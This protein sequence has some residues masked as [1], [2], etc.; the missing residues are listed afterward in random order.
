MRVREL[1][2]LFIIAG[3]AVLFTFLLVPDTEAQWS[4]AYRIRP[5]AALPATCNP[6]NGDIAYLTAGAGSPGLYV[7]TA[8]NTWTAAGTSGATGDSIIGAAASFGWTGRSRIHSAADGRVNFTNAAGADFNR[9]T[10]GPEAVS[11]I[12][13]AQA[14]VA[15]QTQGIRLLRGDGTEQ[16]FASLGAAANGYMIYC[17]DCTKATPCAGGGN[18]ALA[19]RL[20]GAWDCD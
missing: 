8:A 18:G 12:S 20:N 3:A 14:A 4:Y 7:C 2:S 10:F 19:K 15:G 9:I 16:V 13:I 11:H 1:I 6:A 5:V 17:S